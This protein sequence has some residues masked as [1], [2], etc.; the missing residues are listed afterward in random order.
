MRGNLQI[1][2]FW[3]RFPEKE[4][5]SKRFYSSQRKPFG[6]IFLT[7]NGKDFRIKTRSAK[8][9][10][11]RK[12]KICYGFKRLETSARKPREKDSV[13]DFCWK[14]AGKLGEK[15]ALEND[16][17]AERKRFYTVFTLRQ[18]PKEKPTSRFLRYNLRVKK[19]TETLFTVRFAGKFLSVPELFVTFRSRP[20]TPEYRT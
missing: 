20:K 16:F 17:A 8:R 9:F 14:I 3:K 5:V 11:R 1:C 13:L 2:R 4:K 18:A 10:C 15:Q 7:E 19:T 12:E 6:E